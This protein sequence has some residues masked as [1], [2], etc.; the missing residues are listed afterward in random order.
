M[1]L[2]LV[3]CFLFS[4]TSFRNT[5]LAG[6]RRSHKAALQMTTNREQSIKSLVVDNV[7]Q[8]AKI[9]SLAA[10]SVVFASSAAIASDDPL[11]EITNKVFFDMNIDGKPAGRITIGLFGKTVPKTAENFRQLCI[12]DKTS[13]YNGKPLAFKGS[14]FHRIIPEFMCQGGDFTNGNGRGGESIYGVKFPDENFKAKHRAP[15]YISMA[16]AGPNTN[17][18]QFFIT[19]VTT[20]WLDGR[21]VVFGKVIDGFDVVKKMEAQGSQSGKPQALVT[22][23]D[24]GELTI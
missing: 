3:S 13:P 5:F 22:I 11:E 24:A 23:A 6:F 7:L 18:S 10:S 20:P 2:L 19:T 15:G 4:T 17:G 12:G 14:K 21:H 9:S 8:V 1:Y 16:N